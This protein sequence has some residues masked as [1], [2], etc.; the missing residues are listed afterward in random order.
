MRSVDDLV[1][2]MG[3]SGMSKSPVSRLFE[4]IDGKELWLFSLAGNPLRDRTMSADGQMTQARH[5]LRLRR[6]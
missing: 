5:D 2:D 1:K 3:M 6:E 4:E